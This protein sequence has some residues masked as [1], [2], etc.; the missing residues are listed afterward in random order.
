M[1]VLGPNKRTLRFGVFELDTQ[2]GELRRSGNRLKLGD[3]PARILLRMLEKPG[4][5]ITREEL[6]ELL[7]GRD[8][9]V[10]F[11]HGLS[12]AI[13][14][15]REVL[16]D[17]ATNPR[18]IETIPRRGYRFLAEASGDAAAAESERARE[19]SG[20]SQN[21]T[22]ILPATTLS[23][24]PSRNRSR[25]AT[26]ALVVASA[27]VIFLA[28][29]LWISRRHTYPPINHRIRFEIPVPWS[30][31][32][33]AFRLSPDGR[34]LA[35]AAG[36]LW[37][38]PL[39]AF[40]T[41]PVSGTEGATFPFWSPDSQSVGFFAQ[42]KLKK[43]S[44]TGGLAQ[45][46][47]ESPTG[48]GGTWSRDGTIVFS[49]GPIP[50]PLFRVPASGGVPTPVTK[51]TAGTGET[52]RVPEFLPDHRRFLF[53]SST[54]TPETSG[55]YAGSLDGTAQVRILAED[56]SAVYAPGI[57]GG[58]GHLLFRRRDNTLMAQPFDPDRLQITAE[59]LPI[60]EQVG[61]S[62]GVLGFGAFSVS[63]SGVLAYQSGAAAVGNR[64]FT[65]VDRTG[66]RV[67]VVPKPGPSNWPAMS[68]MVHATFGYRT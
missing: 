47:C 48:R 23:Q 35:I 49:P 31:D 34:Y 42:G 61:I 63:Q 37:I 52:H 26:A 36:Q 14:K 12:A 59:A 60:A 45:T 27:V 2:S 40:E 44:V 51:A 18:F 53:L 20:Q 65:W 66:K 9:F 58:G 43:I 62:G 67:G 17:S 11:E 54:A 56:S 3:Q 6:R 15:L 4:E 19:S 68:P 28:G 13:N 8:T 39:D 33:P 55:V 22:T 50:S 46:I 24:E 10:D 1:P 57:S 21:Q 38:R 32:F 41:R 29:V 25:Q 16:G 5:V 7:W 64:R 30:G